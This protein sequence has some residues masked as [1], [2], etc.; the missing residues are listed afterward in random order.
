MT[1]IKILL[2]ILSLSTICQA[3]CQKKYFHGVI[4]YDMDYIDKTGQMSKE[5]AKQY[6]GNEQKYFYKKNKYKSVMNGL[7]NVTQFYTGKDTLYST[8]NGSNSIVYI[9][10][11][12]QKEK[13]ISWR[14]EESQFTVLGYQCK[15]LEVKTSDGIMKYFFNPAVKVN[16]E[17][18][19]NHKKGF[20]FFCFDKTEGALPLKWIIDSSELKLMIKAK[21]IETKELEDSVFKLPKLPII[22]SPE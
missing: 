13:V 14:I 20:W 10:T 5:E 6:I 12:Y 2:I 4:T 22:K 3:F 15:V 16:K 21:K 18:F 8:V 9:N 17:L 7:L 11:K 19:R 1:R